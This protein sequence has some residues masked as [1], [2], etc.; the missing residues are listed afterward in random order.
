MEY[1]YQ[2]KFLKLNNEI[3]LQD[4]VNK[5]LQHRIQ[6]LVYLVEVGLI[7]FYYI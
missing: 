4:F 7:N 1:Y 6:K 5:D 2:K 3:K